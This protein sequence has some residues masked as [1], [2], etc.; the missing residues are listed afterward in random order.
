[1]KTIGN[2]DNEIEKNDGSDILEE[3]QIQEGGS[4][5]TFDLIDYL[6]KNECTSIYFGKI[7]V[8][9]KAY[10]CSVC[11]KKKKNYICDFCHRLC[12]EKCRATLIENSKVI[13]KK[14]KLGFQK[15]V[16]HCGVNLKHIFD[17]NKKV[18]KGNCSM[19]QLDQELKIA[20]YH[21]ITHNLI[22]C[23]ICAVVCHKECTIVP[24]IEVN[25]KQSCSCISDFHSNFNEMALSFPLE[26]YKKISNI[27]IWPVQILNILFSTGTIFNNMKLFFKK[28]LSNEIDFKNQNK[29]VINKFADLLELFSNTFNSKFK[30]YYYHDEIVNM[31][32][33]QKLF[34]FIQNLE[35]NDESTCI[36][37]FRLLF[38]LL[39]RHLR[40]DFQLLKALTSNDFLCNNVLQRLTLKKL[41]RSNNIYSASINTKYNMSEGDPIKDFALK[42]LCS[43]IKNGMKYISIEENQEEFEIGLK[44]LCFMIKRLMFNKDDLIILINSLYDFHVKF[45]EY[46][47]SSKNNIYSLIDIL[48]GII[49]LCLMIPVYYNDIIIEENLENIS[50]ISSTQFIISKS[51]YSNKILMIIFKNCDIF[52]KHYDLL[53]KPEFDQKSKEEKKREE[54]LRKHLLKMQQNILSTTTGV[55]QKLPENGGLLRNK[56]I[57]LFNESLAIFSLTDNIYQK[58]LEY[59]TEEDLKEFKNFCNKIEDE[60]FYKIMK[61]PSSGDHTDILLNLKIVLEKI[62]Y[63]LFTTSYAQQEGQLEKRLKTIILNSCDEIKTNIESYSKMTNYSTIINSTQEKEEN[64]IKEIKDNK[65]DLYLNEEE[66]IKRKILRDIGTN[67]NFAKNKFLLIEEGRE[68]IVDNLIASQIDETLFKGL[69]FLTNIHFPNIISPELVKLYFD[70]L[71]LFLMTKRGIR[72]ILVGKNLKNIQRLINRFRCDDKNKNIV[73]SKGRNASFNLKSIK[74]VINYLN[75]LSKLVK[76]YNIKT[77]LMHKA[78]PGFQKS[79]IAHIKFFANKIKNEEDQIEFKQQ[80]KVCLEIFNNLFEFYSFNEFEYIKNDFIDIF[81]NCSLKLLSP[82]LFQKWINKTLTNFQ[83]PEFQQKRKIDLAFYFQFFELIIKNTSYVYENDEKGKE[84]IEW[85]KIFIDIYNLHHLL[86][87]SNDILTFSQKT[88]LLKFIRTYYLIDYLNQVNYLKKDDLL[89]TEQYKFMINNN[90]VKDNRIQNAI[91]KNKNN[92]DKKNNKNNQKNNQKNNNQK[93]NQKIKNNEKIDLEMAKLYTDKFSFINELIVLIKIYI[94]EIDKFPNSIIKESK[95]SIKKYIN[96]MVFAIHEISTIIYYNKNVINKILP[97]YYKLVINFL[98]K[99]SIILNVMKDI[100]ENKTIIKPE[101]YNYLLEEEY[102]ND[103]YEF[104]I[105]RVFNVFDKDYIYK[106]VMKNI[107]D[108]YKEANLNNNINLEKYLKIYDISNEINF[109]PFSLL[110]VKDYEYFYEEQDEEEV[111]NKNPELHKDYENLNLIRETFIEQ[112]KDITSLAFIGIASGE[113]TNKKIDYGNKYVNLFKSF[114]N[115]TNTSNLSIYRTLLCIMVKLLLYDGEHI[116]SLFKEYAYDKYFFKNINRELN[117]H[118]VQ[119]ISSSKKYELFDKSIKIT[120]IT[121]LTIQFLQLLGEGFN[122]DFH[123]N[124]L[125]GIIKVKKGAKV[126]NDEAGQKGEEGK[127]KESVIIETDESNES[128]ESESQ[129]IHL[130]INEEILEKTINMKLKKQLNRKASVP[131]IE[132]KS[133]IY[134][135]MIHNLR[136]IYH[137]MNLNIQVESELAFDKLCILTSNIIDF[138]IEYLDTKK[139]LTYIID[140]NIKKLFFGKQ[141]DNQNSKEYNNKTGVLPIFTLKIKE[142]EEDDIDR[143]KLRKTMIAYVKIKYYQLLRVYLQIGKKEEFTSLMISNSLGPFQLFQEIIYYMKELINNLVFKDYEKYKHLLEIDDEKSYINKLNTL[144]IYDLDFSTSVEISVVF[145]ICLI[146]ITL[147][148][149][150]KITSLKDFFKKIKSQNNDEDSDTTEKT[151]KEFLVEDSNKKNVENHNFFRPEIDIN[152]YNIDHYRSE[153]V[154]IEDYEI[155]TNYIKAANLNSSRNKII[156]PQ[157]I[158]DTPYS[159]LIDSYKQFKIKKD[160]EKEET[161]KILNKKK[162]NK[163]TL[164]KSN[165]S[166][167]ST[168]VKAIYYF[169]CALVCKVEIRMISNE[170]NNNNNNEKEEK[171]VKYIANK[172]SKGIIKLKNKNEK[173]SYIGGNNKEKKNESFEFD[174]ESDDEEEEVDNNGNKMTFFIKPYLSFHLS[175]SSK[176]YFRNNV[177]RTQ[178]YNKYSS[179]ISFSDYCMFEMMYNLKFINNSN[180]IKVLS[181]INFYYMQVINYILILFENALVMY[182]YYRS[183]SLGYEEYYVVDPEIKNKRFKDILVIIFIKFGLNAFVFFIWFYCKFIITYERNIIF[184]YDTNFIFR[185]SDE[186]PHNINQPIMVNYFQKDGSLLEIMDLINKDLTILKKIKIALFDSILANIEVNIFLFSLILDLFFIIFGSPLFLSI[187]TLLIVGICRSLLNILRAFTDNFTGLIAS[188]FLSFSMLYIYNWLGMFYFRDD[189]VFNEVLEYKSGEYI[190]ESFCTSPIQCLLIF[191]N[192]GFRYGIA[193]GDINPV[194]SY[195]DNAKDFILRFIYD[196]T[197]YNLVTM[198]MWDVIW[199]LIVDSF[200][201]LRDETYSYENDKENVCFICQL[202]RDGCLI[203]S[204]DFEDHINGEHNVWNYVDFLCYLHLYDANNFSRVEGFVWDKLIEKDFGWIPIDNDANDSEEED[205]DE[206]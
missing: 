82:E 132:T 128:D 109:P 56:Y 62:Y 115:S 2:N 46:I 59:I 126:V 78:L 162:K 165:L 167:D 60:N 50:N 144:Y 196:M 34:T 81:R 52:S 193:V 171:N 105:N 142:D 137:L 150:Y 58:Q 40:K 113:S 4:Q 103:D 164:D 75:N 21:C 118:I 205:E 89:T 45:Y 20:P 77:I 135:T 166:L 203:K 44:I 186:N 120:D 38:I 173:L 13:E 90:L 53:I 11:D 185:K 55:T 93:N 22:V 91:D 139:D 201:G 86:I 68:L 190:S 69:I 172:L 191:M 5:N 106:Y 148:D 206:D 71:G 92:N 24:E 111:E 125:K 194:I 83:E 178:I 155:E 157:D 114:I 61:N 108:I 143:Y 107:F 189:F 170:E 57:N 23:C 153:S 67:I 151:K 43:L 181:K 63:D 145:Q 200:G 88:I 156:V 87:N 112:Y 25:L 85:L 41:Y 30:T 116:Q 110:E 14:E 28:F 176:D 39:F 3:F 141:K 174:T 204:I 99:K 104:L 131:L 26:K 64:L 138:I 152:Y 32:P 199:A 84:L 117:Y 19:M 100:Y 122:I 54:K 140:K 192:Y 27:D 183:P 29:I 169:L 168:F 18:N 188:L 146:L 96:E 74:V 127:D 80:L 65:E 17:S 95:K 159:Q 47:M 195:K 49:E 97:Y 8:E 179:L 37:K 124:I 76:L 15:F 154:L 12:H 35:V 102:I 98:K 1:M 121:K 136:I 72:Y 66:I 161:K 187:E 202:S 48:C 119:S 175:E 73:D 182:H 133:T 9:Q 101:D 184:K 160:E 36:I 197:Y 79:I 7:P 134:E 198:I 123:D 130:E 33:Y 163:K 94:N 177:D 158:I 10:I 149:M 129:S 31:L 70:F 42:E 6:S 51:D 180:I 16:C 147:E